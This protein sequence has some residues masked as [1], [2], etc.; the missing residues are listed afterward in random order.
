MGAVA[1]L[2]IGLAL[3]FVSAAIFKIIDSIFST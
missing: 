2:G 1:G 3:T